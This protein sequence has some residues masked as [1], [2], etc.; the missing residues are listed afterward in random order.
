MSTTPPARGRRR[1][2]PRNFY[3]RALAEAERGL[4]DDAAS[5]TGLDDEIALLR[6]L[7]RREL[8]ADEANHRLVLQG[9]ALLVRAVAARYRLEPV[10]QQA[11]EERLVAAVR[12]L[13]ASIAEE[14]SDA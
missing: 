14:A 1:S 2:S 7:V 4:L 13:T 3:R 6:T 10:G 11:L 8:A 12:D 9:L 5:A